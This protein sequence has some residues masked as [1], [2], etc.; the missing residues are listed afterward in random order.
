MKTSKHRYYEALD[1]QTTAQ[2]V[3]ERNLSMGGDRVPE[4]R[5]ETNEGAGVDD[6][7]SIDLIY[8]ELGIKA[9][10]ALTNCLDF[11]GRLG[12]QGG[13]RPANT[14]PFEESMTRIVN[15][16]AERVFTEITEIK[17]L[18]V[19]WE[20]RLSAIEAGFK[21]I[22]RFTI[23]AFKELEEIKREADRTPETAEP[24][25]GRLAKEE[26][27]RLAL[28]AGFRMRQQGKRLTLAAVAREA[29]LKYGQIVY[30]FG[31]KEGFFNELEKELAAGEGTVEEHAV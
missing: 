29:G 13:S 15:A 30:A 5:M 4:R 11:L 24:S 2:R 12:S 22:D 19:Q 10:A 14:A 25:R 8:H 9:F 28:A 20:E 6:F 23:E 26:A 17:D 27:M 7:Q 18:L 1:R 21:R 31:N 16:A 3:L